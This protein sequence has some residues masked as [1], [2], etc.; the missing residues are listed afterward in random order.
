MSGFKPLLQGHELGKEQI[1][2]PLPNVPPRRPKGW[3]RSTKLVNRTLP[4]E[5]IDNFISTY[6]RMPGDP[7]GYQIW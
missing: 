7:T 2:D 5:L 6:P 1:L 3:L 4:C